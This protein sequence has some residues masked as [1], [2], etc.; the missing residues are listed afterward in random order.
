MNEMFSQGGKGSTGILTNK[1]AVA[2]DFGIKQSEVAYAT[3]GLVLDGY[4]A[5]Y[6][7][8][9]QHAF[10]LPNDLLPGSTIVSLT[11]G[12]LVT[13]QGTYDLGALA[14]TRE[15]YIKTFFDFA[16]GGEVKLKNEAVAFTDGIYRWDGALPK[17]VVPGSTPAN[18][19]GIG[20]GKWVSVSKLDRTSSNFTAKLNDVINKLR[21][22]NAVTINCFGDSTTEGY[23]SADWYEHTLANKGTYAPASAY[24]ALLQKLLR[25]AYGYSGVTVNNAGWGGQAIVDGWAYNNYQSLVID[26]FGEADI[27]VITFGLNDLNRAEFTPELY[28]E[29][30][31]QLVELVMAGNTIPVIQTCNT[32]AWT[33]P[34]GL[35]NIKLL[36][37]VSQIQ[38]EVAE[39]YGIPLVDQYTEQTNWFNRTND[40]LGDWLD[41]EPDIL[42]FTKTGYAFAASVLARI[43]MPFIVNIDTGG[44]ANIAPWQGKVNTRNSANVRFTDIVNN[45][46]GGCLLG[47][48]AD[49]ISGDTVVDLWVWNECPLN[50]IEY[51]GVAGEGDFP[52]ALAERPVTKISPFSYG[53]EFT[54]VPVASAGILLPTDGNSISG[55]NHNALGQLPYGLNRIQYILK[56]DIP[57][58]KLIFVGYFKTTPGYYNSRM[59]R[60]MLVLN[61]T[62]SFVVFGSPSADPFNKLYRGFP[63][64]I[65]VNHICV[66]GYWPQDT[67]FIVCE[68]RAYYFDGAT[69]SSANGAKQ[70]EYKTGY[71]IY[72]DT[73]NRIG[74]HQISW[75]VSNGQVWLG[76]SSMSTS[77]PFTGDVNTCFVGLATT[78]TGFNFEL[79]LNGNV[80]H[81][82]EIPRESFVGSIG[83]DVGAIFNGSAHTNTEVA[84]LTFSVLY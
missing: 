83:G 14:V 49:F 59:I 35:N 42:H 75:K 72:R 50:T 43:F 20:D 64:T 77:T 19:G 74:I 80:V 1:Q 84:D 41:V 34:D 3:A 18:S 21:T 25:A 46:V 37:I 73:T 5:V 81:N 16:S 30:L 36:S 39:F 27:T 28:K 51:M 26:T 31:Y 48:S 70:D 17:T 60:R 38:K 13:S 24:P 69:Q 65:G 22:K 33:H 12:V 7:K 57:T 76:S 79:I 58:D 23:G 8:A 10:M 29:K 15:E 2:R 40:F 61:P 53:L 52:I 71:L 67:G 54:E 55:E 62:S 44:I 56:R 11:D 68:S 82:W 78:S 47:S 9:T 45:K 66:S 63:P 6:D 4:K 32:T